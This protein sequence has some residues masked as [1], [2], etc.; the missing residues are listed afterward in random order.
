MSVAIEP[1]WGPERTKPAAAI[2]LSM[3]RLGDGVRSGGLD[4]AHVAVLI[5][6]VDQWPPIVVWG[7]HCEVIDGAHRDGAHRVEAAR[8]VGLGSVRAIRFTGSPD[9]AFVEAVRRNVDHGLPLTASDRRRAALRIL[10]RH[11]EWSD[12][13]IASLCGLSGKTVARLRSEEGLPTA[14]R[15]VIG[16]ERRIG[17]DGKARPVRT[18]R[19]PRT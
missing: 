1:A 8:R 5:E 7:Q 13:R 3:L 18:G 19:S 16:F 17:R 2:P 12:R 6:T 9:E 11:H 10:A 15:V 14:D 4:Q